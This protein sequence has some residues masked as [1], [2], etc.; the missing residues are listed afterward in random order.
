MVSQND[1]TTGAILAAAYPNGADPAVHPNP[2][3]SDIT[4]AGLPTALDSVLRAKYAFHAVGN[5]FTRA[6]TQGYLGNT[7]IGSAGHTDGGAGT[8]RS[9]YSGGLFMQM[10]DGVGSGNVTY[11]AGHG[12][13]ANVAFNSA[14]H[15]DL[16]LGLTKMV[17][18]QVSKADS[19]TDG[20]VDLTDGSTL[21]ANW[22]TAGTTRN[23]FQGDSDGDGDV[24]L[25]DGSALVAAW[26]AGPAPAGDVA[27][28][29]VGS[30]GGAA[31]YD[32]S[33]GHVYLDVNHVAIWGLHSATGQFIG[34]PTNLGGGRWTVSGTTKQADAFTIGELMLANGIS[35]QSSFNVGTFEW[36]YVPSTFGG[37]LGQLLPSGLNSLAGLTLTYNVLGGQ[38]QEVAVQFVPEPTTIGLVALAFGGLVSL[39]RRRRA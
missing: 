7:A 15:E 5:G 28:A 11:S 4:A 32:A 39:M 23:F 2:L 20:N 12:G 34:T 26:T 29:T 25:T 33:N 37:D 21:V 8:F 9:D 27:V 38:E 10:I 24:D 16:E 14:T 3:G 18:K 36:D 19:S 35:F 30:G 17:F 31:Y 1:G 13:G 6:S 22:D